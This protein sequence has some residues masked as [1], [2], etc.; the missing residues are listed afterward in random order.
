VLTT[1]A[2]SELTTVFVS[3]PLI[4]AFTVTVYWLANR[5]KAYIPERLRKVLLVNSVGRI[6][7]LFYFSD[8]W[9]KQTKT[10]FTSEFAYNIFVKCPAAVSGTNELA[11]A[12]MKA[13]ANTIGEVSDTTAEATT[14]HESE[15]ISNLYMRM[16][17]AWKEIQDSGR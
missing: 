17:G 9:V 12:P 8:P 15:E 2:I 7:S 13:V 16:I 10:A 1:Y 14:F 11:Y 5:F 4:I 6:P 3:Q